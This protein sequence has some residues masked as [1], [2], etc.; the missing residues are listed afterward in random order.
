MLNHRIGMVHRPSWGAPMA[1]WASGCLPTPLPSRFRLSLAN[2]VTGGRLRTVVAILVEWVFPCVDALTQHDRVMLSSSHQRHDGQHAGQDRF[3]A[4][5]IEPLNLSL[6]H[7]SEIL[8]KSRSLKDG[9]SA[10]M[11]SDF[12]PWDPM[13]PFPSASQLGG[14][15]S[16]PFDWVQGGALFFQ[17]IWLPFYCNLD[18]PNW[19][20]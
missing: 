2:A 12:E 4:S 14:R 7:R 17:W 1:A 5:R 6:I 9:S 20:T 3:D 8:V 19:Y 13:T 15:I 11:T 16:Q 10:E 18:E